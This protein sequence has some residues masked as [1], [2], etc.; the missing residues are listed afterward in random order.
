[1]HQPNTFHWPKTR[2]RWIISSPC[3]AF[4]FLH[5]M[6]FV[7]PTGGQIGP[8]LGSRVFLIP[9]YILNH[10]W[11]HFALR[12]FSPTYPATAFEV[13]FLKSACVNRMGELDHYFELGD[14]IL[15]TCWRPPSSV[16][17][18]WS[19]KEKTSP[20]GGGN[21]C[22]GPPTFYISVKT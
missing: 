20:R 11:W 12:R 7:G 10:P 8:K 2:L 19:R 17:T 15:H 4:F 3:T 13:S 1:M 22:P 9:A 5:K 6:I 21:A 14:T 18:K 16:Y